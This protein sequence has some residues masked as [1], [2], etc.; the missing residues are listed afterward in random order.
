MDLSLPAEAALGRFEVGPW[1]D[2]ADATGTATGLFTQR[3]AVMG[4]ELLVVGRIDL[5]ARTVDTFPIGPVPEA[6]SVSFTVSAD[7]RRA[8]ILVARI[9]KHELWTIDLQAQRLV[10]RVEVPTR[11]RMQ[12]RPSTNGLF[13]I[14]EAGR[15]IEVY[16]ADATR[17][18]RTIALD[19]DMMYATFVIVPGPAVAAAPTKPR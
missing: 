4:R 11:T 1:D 17:R 2:S 8:N 14:Y 18:L 9:G 5:A 3:D 16:S 19:S 7:H 10:S 12:M 15:T 13:Y 6:D